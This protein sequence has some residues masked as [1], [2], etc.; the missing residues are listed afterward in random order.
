MKKKGS[1]LID[2]YKMGDRGEKELVQIENTLT[3]V[4]HEKKVRTARDTYL[5]TANYNQ[6]LPPMILWN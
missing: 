3:F 1:K 4:K 2:D 6:E 5:Q